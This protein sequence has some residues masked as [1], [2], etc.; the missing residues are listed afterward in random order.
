MALIG[1]KIMVQLKSRELI[2]DLGLG[3]RFV[4]KLVAKLGLGQELRII[5]QELI[6]TKD[7]H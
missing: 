2:Q 6:A 7:F 1:P 4:A 3:S 5:R